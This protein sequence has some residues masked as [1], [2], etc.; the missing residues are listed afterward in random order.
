M[1]EY[2]VYMLHNMRSVQ[3]VTAN[4]EDEALGIGDEL[5]NE[6]TGA[7]FREGAE[8]NGIELQCNPQYSNQEA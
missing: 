8:F 1:K 6:M 2:T 5:L 3:T 4:S 7:D